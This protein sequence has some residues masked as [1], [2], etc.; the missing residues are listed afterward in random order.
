MEDQ[1]SETVSY[2]DKCVGYH[3]SGMGPM[4]PWGSSGALMGENIKNI[5]MRLLVIFKPF[6]WKTYLNTRFKSSGEL[7]S[8]ILV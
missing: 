8:S 2:H 6:I 4:S 3:T 5:F 7:F 1:A